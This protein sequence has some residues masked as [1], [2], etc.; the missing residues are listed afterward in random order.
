MLPLAAVCL[1]AAETAGDLLFLWTGKPRESDSVQFQ[2]SPPAFHRAVA[3]SIFRLAADL[4]AMPMRF[5]ADRCKSLRHLLVPR[6]DLAWDNRVKAISSAAKAGIPVRRG[7]LVV[8]SALNL[9]LPILNAAAR[10]QLHSCTAG[11][12][13]AVYTD[14]VRRK[15][16]AVTTLIRNYVGAVCGCGPRSRTERQS[17]YCR[18]QASI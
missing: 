10:S 2:A 8:A 9:P 5:G 13:L 18:D 14:V 11:G 4:A 16:M 7:M 12:P 1:S 3:G 15:S 17:C 6:A